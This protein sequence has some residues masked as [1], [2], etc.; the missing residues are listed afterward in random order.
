M[1]A[2]DDSIIVVS[3]KYVL[4][5]QGLIACLTPRPGPRRPRLSFFRIPCPSPS[6]YDLLSQHENTSSP[7][8]PS[9]AYGDGG[10]PSSRAAEQVRK[11][12]GGVRGISSAQPTK[13]AYVHACR[14][15]TERGHPP[16][17]LQW[18]DL[19]STTRAREV[20]GCPQPGVQLLRSGSIHR[21]KDSDHDVRFVCPMLRQGGKMRGK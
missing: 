21:S 20:V 4:H 16:P 7:S 15:P 8:T 10:I 9:G 3:N 5:V 11:S 6:S 17:L 13:Q 14:P 12:T 1:S 18:W 19:L 2:G